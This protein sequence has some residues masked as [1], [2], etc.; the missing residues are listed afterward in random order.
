[1]KTRK[2]FSKPG[3][4]THVVLDDEVQAQIKQIAKVEDRTIIA[5]VRVL[6]KEALMARTSRGA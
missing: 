2:P 4:F 3:S 6:I 1:V 5:T